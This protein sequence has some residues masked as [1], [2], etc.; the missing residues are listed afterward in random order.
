[1]PDDT[2][3]ELVLNGETV[4][5]D[6]TDIDG[7]E[8]RTVKKETGLTPKSVFEGAGEMDFEA[9]AALVWIVQRRDDPKLAFDTVLKSLSI[10]AFDVPDGEAAPSV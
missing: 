4:L 8:W 5:I 10:G 9:I 3:I 1:M 6:P 7:C 2:A